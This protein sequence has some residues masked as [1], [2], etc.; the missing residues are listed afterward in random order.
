M[1]RFLFATV[2]VAGHVLPGLPIAKELINR[3]HSVRWYGGAAFADRI[4]RI[5]ASYHPMSGGDYST[6]ELDSFFPAR[7]KKKGI[8]KLQFDM[9]YAFALPVRTA[10]RDLTALLEE[11]PADVVVGDTAF[12]AGP[13]VSELGGPPFPAFGI[14]VV[15]FPA[16]TYPRSALVSLPAGTLSAESGTPHWRASRAMSFSSR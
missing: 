10:V 8:R 1:S 4:R 12:G 14:S 11:E 15:G 6:V 16:A 3:G 9:V 2:P 13:T 7:K 5:G